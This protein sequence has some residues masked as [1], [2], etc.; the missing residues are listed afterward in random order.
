MQK[1]DF[2]SSRTG[3]SLSAI[4]N[5]LKLSSEGATVP[6]IARYR[7][8]ST[9]NMDEVAISNIITAGAEFDLL[10]DRKN[11]ILK[12]IEEQSLLT[13]ELKKNI[14]DCFDSTRLEDLYLP[15]K[16]RKKTLGDRAKEKGLEGLAKIIMAQRTY[17]FENEAGKFLSAEVPDI[18]EAIEGACH[19]VAEWVNEHIQ[20]REYLRNQFV[21]Y[22]K[23]TSKV[24][25]SKKADAGTYTDYFE[26][27]ESLQKSPS[28]RILAMLRGKEEG[29]LRIGIDAGQENLI[30]RVAD[31]MVKP[32]STTA[33]YIHKSVKDGLQRLAFPSIEN[34]VIN[35]YK[36]LADK[37][38]IEVFCENLRQLLLTP[39]LGSKKVLGID[40]GFRT[41]CKVVV[42]SEN[43]EFEHYETIFPHP[44]QNESHKASQQILRLCEK[45]GI[46]AIAIGNGTASRETKDF[47]DKLI[48]ES[49]YPIDAYV[50]SESGASIYS[51]SQVARE[52]FPQLDVTVRGAISIGRRLMDPLAELVKIDP[53]SIGVGQYQ[54]DVDQNLLRQGLDQTV[55]FAV[56]KVGIDINTASPHVLRFVSGLGPGLAQNIVDHRKKIGG[57][58]DR[59]QIKEVPR[60]G[61]KAFEQCAGFLRIREGQN[62]LDNTGVHPETYSIVKKMAADLGVKIAELVSNTTLIDQLVASKYTTEHFGME[63]IQDIIKELK[64]P[65]HDPRGKAKTFS[66]DKN[67]RTIADLA[68]GMS[69]PGLVGNITKFGAFV[70]IGIKENGLL[71]ISEMSDTFIN[72]PNKIVKLGQQLIV[73]I[74]GIDKERGRINLSLKSK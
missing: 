35:H 3:L 38:A 68:V 20:T 46:E 47:V 41:G 44:P 11:T 52:E 4:N 10:Q 7:K 49:Q 32:G 53:K 14:E 13:P 27:S 73:K 23:I 9:G 69:L 56:N 58:S 29:F 34:E 64:K 30:Q 15:Y 48:T 43:G 57:Y 62:P 37:E 36:T 28:H 26:F 18:D 24:V 21:K 1:S 8:E 2:I 31:R 40:P 61:P 71:H 16:K 6:F 25:A 33:E 74:I 17:N 66:F 22:G 5:I 45:F 59:G 72:D 50:V 19:I 67:I 55:V 39:P 42:L 65:G 51:A 12:A 63:T 60:L 70:D 54:H